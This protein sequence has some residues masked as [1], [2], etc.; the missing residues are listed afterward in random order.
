VRPAERPAE[1]PAHRPNHHP[2]TQFI[3][4]GHITRGEPLKLLL[5]ARAVE[6]IAASVADTLPSFDS[7]AFA[8]AAC[9][10]LEALELKPRAAHIGDALW[11]SLGRAAGSAAAARVAALL[12]SF[13]PPL[14]TTAGYGLAPFFYLP[15]SALL[16]AHVTETPLVL[17]A[18]HAL[19]QR[20]TAEFAIRPALIRDQAAVLATFE[21]WA[22][23]TNPHVRRLV[24]EGARP[25]LPWAERLQALDA[26]P[27][28]MLPLLDRLVDDPDLYV[29]RSVANHLGDIAKRH[30]ELAFD[31]CE[32]W[33]NHATKE[34]NWVVRHA[35]RHPA[36][37]G[38]ARAIALRR[39]AK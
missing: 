19:T 6:L 28:P 35:V 12:A 23:D 14:T 9:D 21:R 5:D 20:F 33:L 25:R 32:R 2:A 4:P 15:H 10:G 26:D 1:R 17:E 22:S 24:S 31:R 30:P 36:K 37:Q 11:A 8:Q 38:V 3:A 39:R 13:G 27:R 34:R 18:C 29:R 7:E 16:H